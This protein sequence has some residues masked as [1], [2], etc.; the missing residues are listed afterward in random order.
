M[1]DEC[2]IATSCQTRSRIAV[3]KAHLVNSQLDMVDEI[4]CLNL[5]NHCNNEILLCYFDDFLDGSLLFFALLAN[6]FEFGGSYRE[7]V[8]RTLLHI[9]ALH[10]LDGLGCNIFL[11]VRVV[12]DWDQ[13]STVGLLDEVSELRGFFERVRSFENCRVARVEL[14]CQLDCFSEDGN[15][16]RVVVLFLHAALLLFVRVIREWVLVSVLLNCFYGLDK[17]A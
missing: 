9:I 14:F 10:Q 1:T 6:F 5:V 13:L 8:F 12:A 17:I 7:E 15:Q 16:T 3:L 11:H 2:N 4:N